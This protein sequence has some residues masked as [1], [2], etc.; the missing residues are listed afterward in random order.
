MENHVSRFTESKKGRPVRM[1]WGSAAPSD[2][3]PEV[4]CYSARYGCSESFITTQGRSQHHAYCAFLQSACAKPAAT[5]VKSS[6][7]SHLRPT[8]FKA[9]VLIEPSSSRS[10]AAQP[11]IADVEEIVDVTHHVALAVADGSGIDDVVMHD[12][13][14]IVVLDE[15][16]QESHDLNESRDT[17]L[18]LPPGVTL[19]VE[20]EKRKVDVP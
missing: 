10:H 20:G 17:P 7:V 14:D 13:D 19:L 6:L 2:A 18:V 9:G 16:T 12:E 5:S 8:G 11:V 3:K 4:P 15:D 1:V